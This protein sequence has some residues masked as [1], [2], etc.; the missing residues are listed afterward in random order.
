MAGK[1]DPATAEGQPVTAKRMS[2]NDATCSALARP[3]ERKMIDQR[4][5]NR[6]Q[7]TE[8]SSTKTEYKSKGANIP[9]TYQT[10]GDKIIQ[11]IGRKALTQCNLNGLTVRALLDTG[12][13]VSIVDRL[14]K[15]RYLPSVEVRPL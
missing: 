1:R 2:Q 13:Q 14:W 5:T 10:K 8:S 3:G 6:T 4:L 15:E 7:G 11:L 9:D 12:A